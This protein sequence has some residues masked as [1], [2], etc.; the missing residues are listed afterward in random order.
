M[1]S[2]RLSFN[3]RLLVKFWGAKRYM[4]IFDCPGF[5]TPNTRVVQGSTVIGNKLD[6]E[7]FNI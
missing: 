3:S 5:N 2:V 1:L 4:Q 7:N 6:I